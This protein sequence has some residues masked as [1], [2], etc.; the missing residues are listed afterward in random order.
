M[1]LESV[2]DIFYGQDT[3]DAYLLEEIERS[4]PALAEFLPD[5]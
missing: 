4:I 1:V 5:S 3:I 2:S